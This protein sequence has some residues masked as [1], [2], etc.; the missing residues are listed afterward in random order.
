[1]VVDEC[2]GCAYGD[3]DLSPDAFAMLSPMEAGR[4]DITW[5]VVLTSSQ[6]IKDSIL[7]DYL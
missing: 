5:D 1:M 4:I 3:L 6:S 7:Q 2:P